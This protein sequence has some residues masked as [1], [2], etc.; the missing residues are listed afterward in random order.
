[1]QELADGSGLTY[2]AVE[3]RL[4]RL[5]LRLKDQLLKNLRHENES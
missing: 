1:M 5:R 4:A 2:K 3:S